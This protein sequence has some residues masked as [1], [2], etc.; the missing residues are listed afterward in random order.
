MMVL[1]NIIFSSYLYFIEGQGDHVLI[2]FVFATP[3]LASSPNIFYA[4]A[5]GS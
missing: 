3:I 5:T 1:R 4:L 2:V